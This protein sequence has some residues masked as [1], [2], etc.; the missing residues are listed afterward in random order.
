M[1][2]VT[3][4]SLPTDRN[5]SARASS[6]AITR[7]TVPVSESVLHVEWASWEGHTNEAFTLR[8]DN[9]GWVAE[10]TI[11]GLDVHYVM[12]L[13]PDHDVRQF[14][15]FRDLDDPDLWLVTDGAGRWAE[16]N[17]GE[18][19]DL[20]GCTAVSLA[21]SPSTTLPAIRTLGLDIG[22][23]QSVLAATIDVE[24]LSVVPAEH[25]YTRLEESRWQLAV[26]AF[27]F[28][29]DLDVDE[30]GV[31]I[32]APGWFRRTAPSA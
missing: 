22:G 26:D 11:T 21:C 9:G 17:G 29:V 14:L 1:G 31:L 27:G 32:E 8:W 30:T 18:R 12:R 28:A 24:T 7:W 3:G 15:L 10:G 2:S 4:S 19:E 25:R 23:Q 5:T 20:R 16:M 6:S 13:G